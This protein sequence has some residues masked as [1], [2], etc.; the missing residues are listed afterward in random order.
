VKLYTI[1]KR[2]KKR[3][4]PKQTVSSVVLVVFF[5]SFRNASL[6][7]AETCPYRLLGICCLKE[8]SNHVQN[9]EAMTDLYNNNMIQNQFML[10]SNE[11]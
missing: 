4:Q 10:N 9:N 3:T 7:H 5:L 11:Y 2:K 6:I 8:N 1:K